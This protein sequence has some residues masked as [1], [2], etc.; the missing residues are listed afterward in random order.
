MSTTNTSEVREAIEWI[1]I[2]QQVRIS[3]FGKPEDSV[4]REES[5]RV[6]SAVDLLARHIARLEKQVLSML[7]DKE[8]AQITCF[9]CSEKQEREIA[10]RDRAMRM[11]VTL[12][13]PNEVNCTVCQYYNTECPVECPTADEIIADAMEAAKEESDGTKSNGV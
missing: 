2:H 9:E 4:V 12:G 1:R 8:A 5:I 7:A 13:E 11:L 6:L 3:M 10:K